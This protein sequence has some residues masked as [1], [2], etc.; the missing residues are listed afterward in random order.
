MEAND[1][2]LDTLRSG[3]ELFE[4]Q[5]PLPTCWRT[6]DTRLQHMLQES[7]SLAGGPA[8]GGSMALRRASIRPR[9]TFH[10]VQSSFHPPTMATGAPQHCC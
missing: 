10:T 9:L 6:D 3:N 1:P 7:P 5:Y 8:R 2:G 4:E